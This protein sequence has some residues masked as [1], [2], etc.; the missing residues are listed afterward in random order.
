MTLRHRNS[1]QFNQGAT[2]LT[3]SRTAFISHLLIALLVWTVVTP[4]PMAAQLPQ[5]QNPVQP[6]A[7]PPAAQ[8][9]AQ[10]PAQAGD[11]QAVPIALHL[12]NADLLQVVGI[13]ASELKMNYVV[14]PTV[15]GTVNIN[16]L[17]EVRRGDLFPLLQMILR[18]NGATAVQT[19]NFFRIVPLRD[20][21]RMPIAPEGN[22]SPDSLP[23]DDRIVMNVISLKYVSAPDMTK[24]LTPFM[25]EGGHLFSQDAANILL[26]TDSSRSMNRLLELVAMF[27]TEV[28]ANQRARLFEVKNSQATKLAADLKEIFSAFGLSSATPAVRFIP[29]ER[30]NAVLA[31]T[32]NPSVYPEIERWIEKLDQVS[33]GP[34]LRTFVYKVENG[35]AADV[36][37]VLM[38][39]LGMRMPG[40][41]QQPGAATA[42]PVAQAGGG[43]AAGM[44]TAP[45]MTTGA[46]GSLLAGVQPGDLGNIRI[47]ADTVNNQLVIQATAQEYEQIR[48]T[49][50]DLDVIPR[51][52]MIEAKVYEVDLTGTL[53][54][55]VTAFLRNR[56]GAERKPLASFS[57][58]VLNAS[59]GT[60]VG[61][62]RELMILLNA[63]E[64]H[65]Q[66]RVI[67]APSIL[68]SDNLTANINVGTSIPILTSAAVQQGSAQIGGNSL[69]TNTIQNV[70]TGVLLTITPRISSS[71]LVNMQIQQEVSAPLPVTGPIQ[72]PPIQKRSVGTQVVVQDGETIALG[73]I[74][75]ENRQ[76]GKSR[77]PLLGDIPYVGAL[78]GSTTYSSQRTELIVLLTPTVIR[79]FTEAQNATKE[80]REK[81]R[82]LRKILEE[83][84]E[85]IRED[86]EKRQREQTKSTAPDAS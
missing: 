32:A 67:S 59:V 53:S 2:K 9:P 71:G 74:I 10:A 36:A 42:V 52:V 63:L 78:F 6:P 15:K 58:G 64:A 85:R 31:V 57:E 12:E 22:L 1:P 61:K 45:A 24:I 37:G 3:H 76:L 70:D 55:G 84:E 46:P 17:G 56:T 14:D 72:S 40:T 39:L 18:I 50:R 16:T 7:G 51:Q 75:Q 49:L 54:A 29:I 21:Q 20:V 41:A 43:A 25:S 30:I 82:D 44:A 33:Q 83:D 65:S 48:Q 60:L 68:A 4:T 27:D 11:D 81:L 26:I 19:G 62:T 13:I 23:P 66:A 79:N 77:I 35:K 34:G 47:V 38:Q 8:T 86:R 69:F 73:G 5:P 28:F 80:L